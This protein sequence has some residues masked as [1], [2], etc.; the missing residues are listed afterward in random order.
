MANIKFRKGYDTK[1]GLTVESVVAELVKAHARDVCAGVT[2]LTDSS[3]GT[4]TSALLAASTA[5][6][7]AANSG[8]NLAGKTAAEA[9]LTTVKDALLELA[10]KAN[11]YAV[12]VGRTGLTYNA[13]GTTADGTVGAVT[14]SITAAATGVQAVSVNANL[15]SINS[16]MYHVGTLVN[17]LLTAQGYSLVDLSAVRTTYSSTVAALTIDGGTAA[18][19][20][21][22]KVALDA[23]MVKLRTNVA[24]LAT[25]LNSLNDGLGNAL[26]V[27]V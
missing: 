1:N 23:E 3:G 25:K 26:V 11:E 21:V 15:T 20:G 27:A 22:T 16:I 8:T 5:L 17:K 2:S 14:V 13:G 19:P 9:A 6:V 10:T 7:N 12:K 4:G 18:D 24:T